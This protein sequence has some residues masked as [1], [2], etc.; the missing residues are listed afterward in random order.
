MTPAA[1]EHL[2]S[3]SIWDI[4]YFYFSRF[5]SVLLNR[6]GLTSNETFIL[7]LG[8]KD[9][10]LPS[11]AVLCFY[12]D[13]ALWFAFDEFQIKLLKGFGLVLFANIFLICI[14]WKVYGY[15]ICQRFMKPASSKVIEDLKQSVSQL[16]LPKEHSPRI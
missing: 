7:D 6:L 1:E 11:K 2:D 16:K 5:P 13:L 14:A 9:E 12:D 3:S 4:L 10:E 15:R 8:L